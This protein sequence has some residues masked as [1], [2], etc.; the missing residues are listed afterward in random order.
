MIIDWSDLEDNNYDQYKLEKIWINIEMGWYDNGYINDQSIYIEDDFYIRYRGDDDYSRIMSIYIDEDVLVE[1]QEVYETADSPEGRDFILV[2]HNAGTFSTF[3]DCIINKIRINPLDTI[4]S[5]EFEENSINKLINIIKTVW[6]DNFDSSKTYDYKTIVSKE[7]IA[8]LL[9]EKDLGKVISII[10]KENLYNALS[11]LLEK[12]KDL[13]SYLEKEGLFDISEKN[14]IIRKQNIINKLMSKYWIQLDWLIKDFDNIT[15]EDYV[16]FFNNIETEEILNY[17]I[18]KFLSK[19]TTLISDFTEFDQL[20][21]EINDKDVIN[22]ILTLLKDKNY[23]NILYPFF[24]N[25]YKKQKYFTIKDDKITTNFDKNTLEIISLLLENVNIEDIFFSWKILESFLM[26]SYVDISEDKL[27]GIFNTIINKANNDKN[28]LLE[29]LANYKK[30]LILNNETDKKTDI[31]NIINDIEYILW[32]LD[33]K[34]L[35]ESITLEDLL[36]FPSDIINRITDPYKETHDIAIFLQEYNNIASYVNK[37]IIDTNE[38][39]HKNILS[40]TIT[41]YLY[42]DFNEVIIWLLGHEKYALDNL[43]FLINIITIDLN[44]FIEKSLEIGEKV[45]KKNEE[46]EKYSKFMLEVRSD[47]EKSIIDREV[48]LIKRAFLSK[49]V[50]EQILY[51]H[52]EDLIGIYTKTLWNIDEYVEKINKVNEEL[53]NILIELNNSHKQIREIISKLE[54]IKDIVI[55]HINVRNQSFIISQIDMIIWN[56]RVQYKN[57]ELKYNTIIQTT[58]KAEKDITQITTNFIEIMKLG[59][60]NMLLNR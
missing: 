29:I 35:S 4:F 56:L 26:L 2:F 6:I 41:Y 21:K 32:Q 51:D 54:K 43:V 25:S 44:N 49:K 34:V 20:S 48:P 40:D 37:V 30:L 19:I 59:R 47:T 36:M 23:L 5:G 8:W 57:S 33:E 42:N 3:K 13:K 14:I 28:F 38:T 12:R 52:R 16:Y 60:F 18:E 22:N 24:I 10:K 1:I 27:Q 53:K 55:K 50:K 58:K 15:L 39:V 7:L 11:S 17:L 45:M 9:K 46:I 31:D